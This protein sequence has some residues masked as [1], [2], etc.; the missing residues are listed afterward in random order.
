MYN[1][2]NWMSI[3]RRVVVNT[4]NRFPCPI[5]AIVSFQLSIRRILSP[6]PEIFCSSGRKVAASQQ[7]ES[8]SL[9]SRF[10]QASNTRSHTL[11]RK[12]V[13]THT[14]IIRTDNPLLKLTVK[15]RRTSGKE[16]IGDAFVQK[17]YIAFSWLRITSSDINIVK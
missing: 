4:E 10:E 17:H 16:L 13:N 8:I 2:Y 9:V 7:V 1:K 15:R 5:Q 6:F 3:S 11:V 12:F 14:T